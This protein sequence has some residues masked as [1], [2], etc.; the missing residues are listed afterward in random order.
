MN[1]ICQFAFQSVALLAI[2][3]LSRAQQPNRP[4]GFAVEYTLITLSRYDTEL[5]DDSSFSHCV[6]LQ[7]RIKRNQGEGT[8]GSSGV[9]P[10][11]WKD[12]DETL[13]LLTGL[14]CSCTI[15]I[16]YHLFNF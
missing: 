3:T 14:A 11:E 2:L 9:E 13:S 10:T 6:Q 1:L 7:Y 15:I 16:S 4:R 12:L 8:G 5:D